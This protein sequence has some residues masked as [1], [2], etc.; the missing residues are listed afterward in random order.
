MFGPVNGRLGLI[1][2]ACTALIVPAHA[3]DPMESATEGAIIFLVEDFTVY[4][5]RS[6]LDVVE[7]IPGFTLDD[8]DGDND[9]RGFGQASGN[10]LMNGRRVSGKSNSATDA[11]ARIPV[12]NIKRIEILDG[13]TLDVP[14][15]SG[16][17]V[18]IVTRGTNG[19][20]SGTWRWRHLYRESL[21]PVLDEFNFALSGGSETLSWTLE[22]NNAPS[23]LGAK[24]PEYVTNGAGDLT[25]V[26]LEH[27]DFLG[28]RG[29]V[30]G[31]LAWNPASGA[32]GNL[33]VSYGIFQ[34]DE[35]EVGEI[36]FSDGRQ[37]QRVFRG[38]EDE[39]NLE[40]GADYEFTAGPGRLKTIGLFRLEHS[41][42]VN[43]LFSSDLDGTN[44]VESSFLQDVDEGEFILRSEYS[45]TSPAGHDWQ[46]AAEGAF[47]FLEA[48]SSV[49]TT[50]ALAGSNSRVEE[51]RGEVAVT[52][53]RR[54]TPSVFLQASLGAEVSELSSS[55]DS[56]NVRTYTRPKGFVNLSWDAS[57]TLQVSTRVE[58]EVGQLDFFDFVSSV[59][60]QEGNSDLGNTDLV[61]DQ[62]WTLTAQFD[63]Q[64]GEFGAASL[65]V[66]GSS[67]ED[68]IDR[69]PIGDGDGPGNLDSA[70]QIG[71]VWDTT[72]KLDRIGFAG[73]EFN[74]N[75]E[76]TH[77]R[78]DDPLT[79]ESRTINDDFEGVIGLEL[80]QDV[81]Q[82]DIAWGVSFQKR[83]RN[84]IFQ[85]SE[86]RSFNQLPGFGQFYLEHKDI[87]GMTGTFTWGNLL[88]QN[89][90]FSRVIYDPNRLG[91]VV[92]RE[93]RSRD[94]GP[95]V[96]FELSGTF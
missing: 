40:I 74:F 13:S 24:G 4:A 38:S 27:R 22:A 6:A 90:K 30:S 91:T 28:S 87:W 94:F 14:G 81:P 79:G 96:S 95:I 39:W 44:I 86:E 29:A 63:K 72:F 9:E 48:E 88:S 69:V 10:I 8:D 67:I 77:S 34:K 17:V 73:G 35:K 56:S 62:R 26:R 64:L 55:G 15:L 60:L 7:R 46:L 82:T 61:P 23:R 85:I 66:Y 54:L 53:G 78:V 31:A 21:K 84:R 92:R 43:Q 33:N 37:G 32:V 57:E 20:V 42:F 45:L 76:W 49:V 70:W 65:E 5:P 3:E 36:L 25:E 41:P 58:R 1:A 19:G 51:Q 71:T 89:N 93:S 18:N 68:I 12:D 47:N 75:G 83:Q 50:V 52:H 59:D 11:L 80:R 2:L 16:Q